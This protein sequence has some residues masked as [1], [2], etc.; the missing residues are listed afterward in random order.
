MS[1]LPGFHGLLAVVILG[2]LIFVEESGVPLPL[3]PGDA[4][5]LSGGVLLASGAFSPWVFL[6]TAA[7][8]AIAGGL[9]G[10]TWSRALGTRGLRR[11]ASR[12]RLG[13]SLERLERRV[14]NAGVGGLIVSRLFIPGMRVNTTLLAGAM[15]VPRRR[16]ILA[17]IPSVF[18]WVAIATAV[19][20]VAGVRV[21]ALLVRVDHTLLQGAELFAV[22]IIGYL[23]ARHGPT[24]SSGEDPILVAPQRGRMALAIAIDIGI[25]ATIV[26]SVDVIGREAIGAGIDDLVDACLTAAITVVAYSIAARGG[27]GVTAGE[28]LFHVSYRHHADRAVDGVLWGR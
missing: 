27:F 6:P 5:L 18:I 1:F 9:V 26:A 13:A 8:S 10:Y 19:G 4:L 3:V 2:A 12:L 16:F 17:L 20:A 14:Q 21:Q 15:E 7:V 28:A 11:L 22:G 24:R 25:I 23:A